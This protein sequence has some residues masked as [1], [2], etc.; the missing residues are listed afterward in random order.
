MSAGAG[1]HSMF[2]MMQVING[3]PQETHLGVFN[4]KTMIYQDF[5]SRQV[6]IPLIT[7]T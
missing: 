4:F 3:F 6:L 1:I 5:K 7:L 2:M